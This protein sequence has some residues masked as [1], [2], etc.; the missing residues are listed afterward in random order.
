MESIT[1]ASNL[2]PSLSASPIRLLPLTI[3]GKAG[4]THFHPGYIGKLRGKV[5][6]LTFCC[7]QS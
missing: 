5:T 3:S 6:N 7:L 1:Y 2:M 4:Y